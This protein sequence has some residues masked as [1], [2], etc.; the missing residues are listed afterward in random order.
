MSQLPKST[1]GLGCNGRS[2]VI[3]VPVAVCSHGWWTI[4]EAAACLLS[5]TSAGRQQAPLHPPNAE[6]LLEGID[7]LLHTN[8]HGGLRRQGELWNKA[9]RIR[10]TCSHWQECWWGW[11]IWKGVTLTFTL[12]IWKLI[13]KR[14]WLKSRRRR[15][16]QPRPCI[17]VS[18]QPS[19]PRCD[20]LVHTTDMQMGCFPPLISTCWGP[21]WCYE[22]P[23]LCFIELQTRT[24]P[25]IML[26]S[27]FVK[28]HTWQ[29][30]R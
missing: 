17:S 26:E 2:V 25:F 15:F 9:M 10:L 20:V 30:A 16:T 5:C 3:R 12:T 14:L 21:R 8:W 11:F 6:A 27:L 1:V 24:H 29:W 23:Q 22:F 13:R 28:C 18:S 19:R 7:F 4:G